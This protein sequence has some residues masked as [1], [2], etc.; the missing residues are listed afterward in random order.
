MG[1]L[2]Y[3]RL[4]ASLLIFF[5]SQSLRGLCLACRMTDWDIGIG[6]QSFVLICRV[7]RVQDIVDIVAHF[8]SVRIVP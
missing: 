6:Q 8:R 7:H 4:H 2:L 3:L 5:W 1:D